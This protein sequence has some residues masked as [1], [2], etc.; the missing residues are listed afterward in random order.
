MQ[1]EMEGDKKN[2]F[3]NT[4][5]QLK[6]LNK[7][8][9]KKFIEITELA[10]TSQKSLRWHKMTLNKIENKLDFLT[11]RNKPLLQTDINELIKKWTSFTKPV[12][13]V[14]ID[15]LKQYEWHVTESKRN[16]NNWKN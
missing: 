13:R 6:S 8:L 7:T 12:Y 1:N 14:A 10:K 2:Q 4:F 3:E 9:D 5:I 16:K 11:K 15:V